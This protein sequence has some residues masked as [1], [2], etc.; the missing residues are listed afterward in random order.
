M[1]EKKN[2]NTFSSKPNIILEKET[3]E[4]SPIDIMKHRIDEMNKKL[5]EKRNRRK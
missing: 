5:F 3:Q 4:L 2:Q 1:F